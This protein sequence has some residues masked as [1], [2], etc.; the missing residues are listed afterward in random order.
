MIAEALQK[1]GEV[2]VDFVIFGGMTLKSG[3]QRE[4]FYGS[5]KDRY[6]GLLAR[7]EEIYKENVWGQATEGYYSTINSLFNELSRRHRIARRM[8]LPFTGTSYGKTTWW[9]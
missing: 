4:Y 9:S 8:P 5:L 6:P 7:Y 3:R 1:A 2:G